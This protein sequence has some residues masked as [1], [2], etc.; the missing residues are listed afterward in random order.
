MIMPL[1]YQRFF[2]DSEYR[3]LFLASQT[4]FATSNAIKVALSHRWTKTYLGL[5]DYPVFFFSGAFAQSL[6]RGFVLM[7]SYVIVAKL[8]PK[9]IESTMMAVSATIISLNM[10]TIR[11]S[12]G[13]VINETFVHVTQ[14]K[15]GDYKL[16]TVI[17][18]V[19]SLLPFTYLWCLM[20]TNEQVNAL[21]EKYAAD[22][23]A[24]NDERD[25][26]VVRRQAQN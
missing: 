6:E 22:E 7:P 12:L 11:A 15:F 9:G 8:I 17:Q 26:L 20:P 3:N 10:F 2:K 21:S 18:L 14:D 13:V 16:L 23:N 5:P 24:R 1:I 4:I 25:R 19:G